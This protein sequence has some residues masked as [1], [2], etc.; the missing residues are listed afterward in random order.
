MS[1]EARKKRRKRNQYR[2][3]LLKKEHE[4]EQMTARMTLIMLTKGAQTSNYEYSALERQKTA[5]TRKLDR[6][7]NILA[8]LSPAYSGKTTG[9]TS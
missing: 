8:S 4:L 6:L 3:K 7:Q 9:N 1:T 5:V 2:Q